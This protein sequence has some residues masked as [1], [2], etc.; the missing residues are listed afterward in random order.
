METMETTELIPEQ[1]AT[2]TAGLDEVQQRIGPRFARSEQRQ[3]VRRYLDGVLSPVERKNGWQLAE[4]AGEA[5]PYGMQRLLAGAKWDAGAVRDDLRAYVVEHLSDP[6][7]VLVIDE[8]GFL[9]QG[10]KSVGVKRQYSGTAGRIEN[11]QIGVFLT[12]AAPEGHVLLDRELYLPREWADAPDRRQEAGVPDE[13]A[14][15]TKPQLA[16]RMLERALEAGVP[17]AW[18]TGDSIYGG[19]RRLR[20]WLEQQEQP[21]V[22]AVTSAEPLFAVLDGHWGEP[23]ADAIAAHL[24][25]NAWQRLS[26]GDGAKGPRWYDWA[27]VRL[28][29]LQ[30]SEA[31]RRWDHWLLVRRSRSDPTDLAYYVVFAPT[32]TSL[33]TLARVAGQRWR[34]EQSFELAKGEVGLDQYEVR[35]WDG[36]YRHMTLAMFALAYLAVLRARLL[37][38]QQEV[39]PETPHGLS[40]RRATARNAGKAQVAKGGHTSDRS[41]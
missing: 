36:W 33:R 9:K 32:G 22:L 29:R 3:R 35:R 37:Q 19:D 41:I 31:E 24:P 40:S 5:R 6:R 8:T 17:A 30:L 20:V 34:I 16:R 15:A 11:C 38:A 12:Y 2:W 21:F 25:A 14:F 13:V 39:S 4:H 23:R 28:A 27:R 18:V 10:T 7:A 26:A 1:L